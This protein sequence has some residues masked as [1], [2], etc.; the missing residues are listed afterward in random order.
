[1]RVKARWEALDEKSPS[2]KYA[3]AYN[4]KM[5]HAPVFANGDTKSSCKLEKHLSAFAERIHKD[6]CP[7]RIR[8]EILFKGISLIK[9][10][11]YLSMQLEAIYHRGVSLRILL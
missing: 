4:G 1:M 5:Y 6:F 9:R 11:Y 8:A 3:K 2:F 10:G 7:Q